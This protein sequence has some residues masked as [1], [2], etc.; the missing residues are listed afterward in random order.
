MEK[1]WWLF[2]KLKREQ[3]DDPLIVLLGRY[4]KECKSGY[5]TGTH[6]PMFIAWYSQYLSYGNSQD[7]Q[8]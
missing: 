1:V 6:T 8:F 4:L 2:K 7:A 5:N 3:P